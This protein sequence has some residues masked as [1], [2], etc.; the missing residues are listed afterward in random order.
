MP[1]WSLVLLEYL[2]DRTGAPCIQ[3]VPAGV[4]A[5]NWMKGTHVVK[6][7]GGVQLLHTNTIA[8]VDTHAKTALYAC[9][10]GAPGDYAG[11]KLLFRYV[12]RLHRSDSGSGASGDNAGRLL[13]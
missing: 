10:T 8:F 13:L 5:N 3:F 12:L 4:S 2:I 6:F 11:R 1:R 9:G 7:D